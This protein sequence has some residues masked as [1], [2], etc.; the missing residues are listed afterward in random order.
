MPGLANLASGPMCLIAERLIWDG[1]EFVAHDS[2][3]IWGIQRL[4]LHVGV[5]EG[6]Q[7]IAFVYQMFARFGEIPVPPHNSTSN[8]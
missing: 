4:R 6:I 7:R 5:P 3:E 2:E 8:R 1:L